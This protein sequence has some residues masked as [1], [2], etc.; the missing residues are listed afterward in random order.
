MKQGWMAV[1]NN[2]WL[3]AWFLVPGT[4]CVA[5]LLPNAPHIGPL[6]VKDDSVKLVVSIQ[7]SASLWAVDIGTSGLKGEPDSRN[8]AAI[9]LHRLAGIGCNRQPLGTQ[10]LYRR[11]LTRCC[12]FFTVHYF[13]ISSYPSTNLTWHTVMLYFGHTFPIYHLLTKIF[14]Y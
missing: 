8:R 4:C 7:R 6:V 3:I 11:I 2:P 9:G 13:W 12:I 1:N 14:K 5:V 10:G